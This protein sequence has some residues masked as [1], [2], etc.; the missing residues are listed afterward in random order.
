[1]NQQ[2]GRRGRVRASARAN[3][4]KNMNLKAKNKSNTKYRW[5]N[6]KLFCDTF[7]PERIQQAEVNMINAMLLIN[8]YTK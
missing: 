7:L 8:N 3:P 6:G 1:M 2:S 5:K 4:K